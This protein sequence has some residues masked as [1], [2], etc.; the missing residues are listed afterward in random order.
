MGLWKIYPLK[1]GD[2]P[3][4]NFHSL[5]AFSFRLFHNFKSG[6]SAL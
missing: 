4:E 2:W 6:R 5:F 1:L 3:A